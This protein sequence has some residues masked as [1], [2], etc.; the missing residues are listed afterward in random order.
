MLSV[1]EGLGSG[2]AAWEVAGVISE[3]IPVRIER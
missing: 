2:R 3:G 1:T